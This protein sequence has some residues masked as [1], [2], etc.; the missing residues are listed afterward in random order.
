MVQIMV[1]TGTSSAKYILLAALACSWTMLL[2]VDVT[3]EFRNLL[4]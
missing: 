2:S 1:V 3:H 4:T